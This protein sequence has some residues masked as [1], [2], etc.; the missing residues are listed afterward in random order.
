MAA[1]EDT[2]MKQFTLT[3]KFPPAPKRRDWL[4]IPDWI[5]TIK[6]RKTFAVLFTIFGIANSVNGIVVSDEQ[7]RDKLNHPDYPLSTIHRSLRILCKR[8]IIKEA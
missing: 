8:G 2:V 7:V 1:N 5:T 6:G 3:C 4:W